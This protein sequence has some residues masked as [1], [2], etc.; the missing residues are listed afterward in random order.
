MS[1]KKIMIHVVDQHPGK[2]YDGMEV[3]LVTVECSKHGIFK[4]GF[5]L[6]PV[7]RNMFQKDSDPIHVIKYMNSNYIF[8][9]S[10]LG[11]LDR[12]SITILMRDGYFHQ[13]VTENDTVIVD[14]QF[15][16]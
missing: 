10:N 2:F 14:R 4:T 8:T 12:E 1:A 16:L 13:Y 11:E 5:S 9:M 7:E 6:N 15:Y 3:V